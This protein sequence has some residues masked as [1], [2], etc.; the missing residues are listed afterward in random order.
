MN[1]RPIYYLA[2]IVVLLYLLKVEVVV[3]LVDGFKETWNYVTEYV[4]TFRYKQPLLF[5][6]L[7]VIAV[8]CLKDIGE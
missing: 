5:L 8:W 4:M 7:P 6:A 1:F 3:T 2:I